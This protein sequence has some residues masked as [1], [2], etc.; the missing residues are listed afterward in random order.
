MTPLPFTSARMNNQGQT[1]RK[2]MSDYNRHLCV[3]SILHVP[4]F[5]CYPLF[6][7]QWL[8]EVWNCCGQAHFSKMRKEV[9]R[10]V[11]CPRPWPKAEA[12]LFAS[13]LFTT[14]LTLPRDLECSPKPLSA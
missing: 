2:G 1:K 7:S 9:Q 14:R 13:D 12:R 10:S 5:V 6:S 3:L 4:S 11:V 8:C